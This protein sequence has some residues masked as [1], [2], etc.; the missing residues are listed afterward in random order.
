[1]PIEIGI[2]EQLGKVLPLDSFTF[3]DENGK[4]IVLSELF[5]RPIILT[6]VYFRCPGICT[7]LL[8]GTVQ[9]HQHQRH[10]AG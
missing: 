1:M 6:L 2:D 9:E 4:P 5:D 10:A 7:P 8:Q 3:A